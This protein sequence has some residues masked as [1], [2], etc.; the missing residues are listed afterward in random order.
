M[1][2]SR[3]K[4]VGASCFSE[5]ASH[6]PKYISIWVMD[7]GLTFSPQALVPA[8]PAV[9]MNFT[10]K[11]LFITVM[12]VRFSD[13]PP[14]LRSRGFTPAYTHTS[15]LLFGIACSLRLA[16]LYDEVSR[17]FQSKNFRL[18][19]ISAYGAFPFPQILLF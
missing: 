6:Y 5:I 18:W 17:H 11:K 8:L 10:N 4:E 12:C 9:L 19:Y 16:I 2:Y 15:L 3:P 14:A 1:K 7:I 13:L